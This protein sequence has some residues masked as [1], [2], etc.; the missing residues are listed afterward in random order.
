[1]ESG[2]SSDA[3][4]L[5]G[6]SGRKNESQPDAPI[7]RNCPSRV[8][9]RIADAVSSVLAE[10]L[11]RSLQWLAFAVGRG[12]RLLPEE[13]RG[14]ERRRRV[15]LLAWPA[16]PGGRQKDDERHSS[17]NVAHRRAKSR[18]VGRR[19]AVNPPFF[20]IAVALP[21]GVGPLA[22]PERAASGPP[23]LLLVEA[24]VSL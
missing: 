21:R 24:V 7:R 14:E 6:D 23:A 3:F 19:G 9:G 15:G 16:R 22:R 5:E 4:L 11:A 13:R 8:L 2:R 18:S 12:E 20:F 17:R 1:M 10:K